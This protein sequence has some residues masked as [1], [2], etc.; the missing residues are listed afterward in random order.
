MPPI[1]EQMLSDGMT[2]GGLTALLLTVFAEFA[3][4]RRKRI[5]TTLEIGALERIRSFLEEFSR[6][7]GLATDT[8]T[9]LTQAAE[10]T[11]LLLI[12]EDEDDNDA[13]AVRK[14]RLT[15]A[16]SGGSAELEFLAS[17]AETN[18][19]DQLAVIEGHAAAQPEQHEFSLRLLRHLA[20]SV[21]HHRYQDIDIVTLR[22]DAVETGP[23]QGPDPA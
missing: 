15:V 14:L 8:A 7:R 18:I 5:D 1:L 12:G 3:G 13:A 2:V 20:S 17:G 9:R 11:I 21:R 23:R 19:E 16:G 6:S 10:E 22:V 4:P